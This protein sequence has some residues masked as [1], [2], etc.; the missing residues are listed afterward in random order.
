MHG[1]MGGTVPVGQQ[2]PVTLTDKAALAA[3]D[4]CSIRTRLEMVLQYLRPE[5]SDGA[6]PHKEPTVSESV[7]TLLDIAN[8]A[9]LE[10]KQRL[11]SIERAIGIPRETISS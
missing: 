11:D 4:C 7:D 5:P 2:P 9:S 10:C 1:Q 3:Q 6:A 8:N